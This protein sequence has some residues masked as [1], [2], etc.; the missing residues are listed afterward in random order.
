MPF[1]ES[2]GCSLYYR[3]DGCCDERSN[4]QTPAPWLMLCNSLGTT[5]E[6]WQPQIA[7]LAKLFRVVRYDRRGHGRSSASPA[8]H[9][10]DDL[11]NDALAVLDAA[12]AGRAHFCGLSIGG[13]VG[14]WLALRAPLRIDRLVLCSTAAKIGSE[15]TWRARIEQL[16]AEGLRR[17]ADE[18]IKRWFTAGFTTANLATINALRSQFFETSPECYVACCEVLLNTDLTSALP[19]IR[20]P[21]LAIAGRGDPVTTPADLRFIAERVAD[22]LYAEVAGAHLCNIESPTTFNTAVLNFLNP[23][24]AQHGRA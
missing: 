12:G 8:P 9:S 14:Q 2:A 24:E 20:Q 17:L 22:G 11:A 7:E 3:V 19:S 13:L 10:L 4:E 23:T 1:T 5:H 16:R 15:A 6:M 21:T 18:I